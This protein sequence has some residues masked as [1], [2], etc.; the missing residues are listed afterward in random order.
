[1]GRLVRLE[2]ENFKSYRGF[3]VIGPFYDF[4][5]II[6]PNGAGKS[7]LM[8]AIS[9][10][11]GIKSSHLRS[12]NLK[13]LIYRGRI[14]SSQSQE[15]SQLE[16]S[17][18]SAFV[19]LVFALDDGREVSFKRSVSAAGASEYS[20]DGRTV[21]FSEYTK[22]LEE[23]NILVKAR[24]FLVFQGDIEAIAAQSP[25]DL[26]RLIEQIS[27]SLEYK[28]EYDVLKEKQDQAVSLSAHTFN[29][30][31]G[32]NAE[33]RQ[34]QDQ[35][36]EA[37]LYET[38]KV[39]K[40]EAE[41][42]YTLWK[43]YHIEQGSRTTLKQIDGLKRQL[44]KAVKNCES[45]Q[46]TLNTLRSDEGNVH[47]KLLAID[48]KIQTK[49]NQAFSHRPEVLSLAER[50]ARS[51]TNV[52]KLRIKLEEVEKDHVAQQNTVALLK[53]QLRALQMAEEQFLNELKESEKSRG[54]QFTPQQEETY[55]VLRQ[56]VDAK[57][58]LLL[59]EVEAMN[60]R[61][62]KDSQ[63]LVSISDNIKGIQS[64]LQGLD[65]QINSLQAEKELLTTDVNDKLSALESKKAEH[66]QKRTKLV[67]LTQEEAILNEKLQECLRK[68]LEVNAMSHES[69]RETKKR[70]ALFSLKR[71]YP[72]VK[73]RVVDLCRP[74][75]KKY[76]TAIAAALGRN[77]ESIVVESHTIAKECI[78]YIRDQRVGVMTFLPMDTIAAK[79]TNQNLRGA[80]TGARLAIDIINYESVY[81]RV[82]ASVLGDTLIC[83][84]MDIARD[85]AY[86]RHVNS[87]VITL[88]GTV[89]HKTGLISGG[90]SRNNNRHWNDQEVE[91]LKNTQNTLM[92]KI[93]Q[94]HDE[95]SSISTLENES[96]QLQHMQTQLT[97]VR[98]N[99]SS[100][101][102]SLDDKKTERE[103]VG[104]QLTSL[105]PREGQLRQ[106]L[107]TSKAHLSE[108]ERKVEMV[109]DNVFANFCEEVGISSI[110]EYDDYRTSFAQKFSAR[111]LEF[112]T[113]KSLVQNQ[114]SFESQRLKETEQRL[115]KLKG[116]VEKE[117]TAAV[118]MKKQKDSLENVIATSEAEMELLREDYNKLK[119]DNEELLQRVA[120]ERSLLSSKGSEQNKL[121]AKINTLK[122]SIERCRSD[123]QGVLRKCKL[124]D[125]QIPLLQGNLDVV[126]IDEIPVSNE[127]SQ[128]QTDMDID[129]ENGN[130]VDRYGIVVNYDA[131]DDELREDASESMG[132]V[133]EDK[134][135]ELAQEIEQMSPNMKANDRLVSTEQRLDEL[136]DLFN[137]ARQAAKETKEKFNTV[138]K[139]R[140]EKFL[141]AFNHI[142]EQI[143]PIYKEL[144]KSKA[145]PMGGTAYLTLDDTDEPY[146]GGVKF[147]AMPPMKRFRD[148][149]QLSGGEKTIAAM[150]LL[151]AI[152][153]FQPSPFFVL[154]EVDAA[155]D[156]ANVTHI[157]NYIR[158]HASQGFQFVVISLK[159]QLFSKS[160]A[161]VGIYRDQV[162]NSS[163]TLTLNLDQYPL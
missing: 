142:S 152:H 50:L 3:Q 34:Y 11:V 128:T 24:N 23:Q 56:E 57:N 98:D 86:R 55:N 16:Q 76:E 8:D 14:L 95:K 72:E 10:V 39:Q 104:S 47:R 54:I 119:Q 114:L 25:D 42:V 83:D 116:Y 109:E 12:S 80:Y 66:S 148:M 163:R 146:L 87:K 84:N 30:K 101:N 71:I 75:Q 122:A 40:N 102:R 106:Q 129:S 73:G 19:K 31:R 153:S 145:F 88:E 137:Q 111:K 79:P 37:E 68:L 18:Q 38:K 28:R 126:P 82:M 67:Q 121:S 15:S 49:K 141:T 100:V 51:S 2:V 90:T 93:A 105:K 20:I 35:K 113:Q 143:D 120:S 6:G 43:L 21:S 160:E 85:L 91:T 74:T 123:W 63:Q 136:D 81:E 48:R 53:D 9:F 112:T 162:Q 150:A 77:F 115:Q 33:L 127:P 156:Q 65:E 45:L 117:E 131:L 59:P 154:D 149:E 155:L 135:K 7:N 61:I 124:D 151:F 17:P 108:L 22:A 140:L 4:T 32:V 52:N 5:S 134:I 97:L 29:K 130:P 110:R 26:C 69:R 103:H 44:S 41:L 92:D 161:L 118:E 139:L 94:I 36:A 1:M 147:H 133:L 158:E 138:K 144:T 62:K 78:N 58:S 13:D 107:E 60:R 89:I 132:N 159:N 70:D 64:K 125:L 96:M 46:S 157:A 27:G 99:L